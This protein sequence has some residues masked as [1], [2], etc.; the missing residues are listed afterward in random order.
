MPEGL[1]EPRMVIKAVDLY[2]SRAYPAGP[3]RN[4]LAIAGTLQDGTVDFYANPNF[5]RNIDPTHASYYLR[6]GNVRYPHAKLL[7]EPW[8]KEPS[9]RRLP[10]IVK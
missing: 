8:L 2:L 9:R 10:F 3:P 4:I 6:L 5:I 1:P 7:I